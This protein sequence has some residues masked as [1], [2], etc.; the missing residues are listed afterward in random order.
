MGNN[1]DDNYKTKSFIN[2]KCNY[3]RSYIGFSSKFC[4]DILKEETHYIKNSPN[5]CDN[6]FYEIERESCRYIFRI[7]QEND[8]ANKKKDT[9]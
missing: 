8:S 1:N 7:W 5:F 6:R 3:N 4:Q 2:S 9:G